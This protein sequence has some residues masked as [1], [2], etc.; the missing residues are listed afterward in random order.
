LKIAIVHD[1][2][3][4]TGGAEKLVLWMK[5]AFPDASIFT[6]V[7]L[8]GNTFPEFG[9][10]DILTLP[11]SGL[12]KNETQMKLLYPIW[13]FGF[14]TLDLSE[15]DIVLSSST[16][17][18][19]FISPPPHVKHLSYINAPFR[20]LW[21]LDSYTTNNRSGLKY[22]ATM[23]KP[24]IPLIRKLDR[25]QTRKITKIAAN[26]KN[27]ANAI[28]D[29]YQMPADIIFPPVELEKFSLSKEKG[30]YFISVSRLVS[31]KRV[32]IAVEACTKLGKELV[33]VGDGPELEHLKNIAGPT[34]R[35]VGKVQSEELSVLYRQAKALLFPSEEDFG[36][37]PLEAQA[38]GIPVIA[39]GKG[40]V[41]ETVVEGETGLF[42]YEQTVIELLD[43]ITKFESMGF[44]KMTIRKW[45]EK[46]SGSNFIDGIREFV[47]SA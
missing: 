40:G 4:V 20:L 34:I 2:L 17:L 21:K 33:V 13:Y 30:T 27:M 37:V 31:H 46:F 9:K 41:L 18:A 29:I 15:F 6:S 26:S 39:F 14:K 5:K 8:P 25:N 44:N 24:F 10:L 23:L 38:S 7:Y 32:D 45:A 43:A 19:K 11:F 3:C 1:A 22:L 42:F 36:I 16:Y 12:V 35:F 47:L 28:M